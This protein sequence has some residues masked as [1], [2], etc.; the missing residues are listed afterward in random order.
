MIRNALDRASVVILFAALA[1]LAATPLSAA[2][3]KG[4][5]RRTSSRRNW[6]LTWSDEFNGPNGS[7]PDPAKWKIVVGGHGFGNNELETY[8]NRPVNVHQENGRLV[9]TALKEDFTGADN[10]SRNY[11]SARLETKGLFEQ[12][13]GRM[14]ARIQI[15][16][17]GPGIWPAFWMM[18]SDVDL[19]HWPDCG[20]V[21]IMENIGSEPTAIHG[22]LHGPGYSGDLPLTGIYHLPKAEHVA[23]RYH[24]FAVE[25]EPGKVHFFID[26]VQYKTWSAAEIPGKRWVFDHPFYLLLDVAVGGNWPGSPNQ[27]TV[28]PSSML[29]DYV[30]VYRQAKPGEA[31]TG[32]AT[33]PLPIRR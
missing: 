24:L 1:T 12:Q 26:N 25:W 15:P 30:R 31:S 6:I 13:Y 8:T 28:F 29:V 9:M 17:G 3:N 14:E 10:I 19:V 5:M 7:L 21:D 23:A 22:S 4:G 27:H 16:A 20:E 11:T 32:T 2:D 18:G 33:A